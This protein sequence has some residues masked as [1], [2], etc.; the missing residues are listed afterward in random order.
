MMNEIHAVVRRLGDGCVWVETDPAASCSRCSGGQACSTVSISRLFCAPTR[1]FCVATQELLQE[2]DQV[3]LGMPE[4]KIL[5]AALLGYG[6]P[7]LGLL[8]GALLGSL[9]VPA[10][11]WVSIAA[12]LAG[13]GAGLWAVRHAG[14]KMPAPILLGK[15]SGPV[16]PL[17]RL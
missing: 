7:V 14:F 8:L 17:V 1:H 15:V 11:E 3:R 5:Y 4:G 6:L 13:F 12:G 2:G 9:L 16:I 10:V